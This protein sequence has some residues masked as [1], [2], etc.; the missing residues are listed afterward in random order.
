MRTFC[1]VLRPKV[2]SAAPRNDERGG[3]GGWVADARCDHEKATPGILDRSS[4]DTFT[5]QAMNLTLRSIRC[6]EKW[7]NQPG[8]DSKP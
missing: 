4:G 5:P 6:A 1:A 8:P 7:K 2:A 3:H